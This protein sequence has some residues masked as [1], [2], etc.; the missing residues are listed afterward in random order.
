M[1]KQAVID[2]ITAA[3]V[4]ILKT[5]NSA[6]KLYLRVRPSG[7]V[8]VNEETSW[9]C[10]PDEYYKRVPHTLSI[11]VLQSCRDYSSL[12]DT[13]IEECADNAADAAAELVDQWEPEID[14][15]IGA[16]NLAGVA[17]DVTQA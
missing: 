5:G 9:C 6:Q 8:D 4:E 17:S 16:G 10:S 14:V 1:T 12:T 3:V 2:N 15:W 13:E 7:D 11:E